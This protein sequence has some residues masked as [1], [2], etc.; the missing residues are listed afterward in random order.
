VVEEEGLIAFAFF[1]LMFV[2]GF[3]KFDLGAGRAEHVCTYGRLAC[4]V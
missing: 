3:E 1:L 2:V 4:L